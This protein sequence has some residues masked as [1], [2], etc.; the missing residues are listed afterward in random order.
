MAARKNR[1]EEY[2]SEQNDTKWIFN[3]RDDALKIDIPSRIVF[4][5]RKEQIHF[6]F[7]KSGTPKYEHIREIIYRGLPSPLPR[8]LIK[9]VR[10]GYGFTRVLAP[11]LYQI[12]KNLQPTKLVV[13]LK[14]KVRLD[15]KT[16]YLNYGD[17][18]KLY[19]KMDSLLQRQS[20]EK[21]VAAKKFLSSFF[22]KKF[23]DTKLPYVKGTIY[24]VLSDQIADNLK[25]ISRED[26]DSMLA[27]VLKELKN[28]G[29]ESK[30][31]VL[32]TR[33]KIEKRFL[34]D[35]ISSFKKL[36]NRKLNS[37]KLEKDWETLLKE[38]PWIISNLFGRR[39]N[40]PGLPGVE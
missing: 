23:T 11:I 5:K 10:L 38:N 33:E 16:L 4:K 34:E 7:S 30:K 8:G 1:R 37:S 28:Q 6:P 35:T 26:F 24:T 13:S 3:F 15:K 27:L 21:E 40:T 2:L 20:K 12:D 29:L 22:P 17:L 25:V 18:N 31:I 9:D 36:L 39:Q 32:E 14:G 19:P